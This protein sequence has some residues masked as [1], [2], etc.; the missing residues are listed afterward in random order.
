MRREVEAGILNAKL[1]S[2]SIRTFIIEIF[3]FAILFGFASKS[4]IV[5][6]VLVL[7]PLIAYGTSGIVPFCR[8]LIMIFGGMYSF[9][10]GIAVGIIFSAFSVTAGI[11]MG[12][13][14]FLPV[15]Y[16]NWCAINYFR[17]G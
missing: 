14:V 9:G 1:T 2:H 3:L 4:W 16:Y 10:W 12:V 13:I 15:A 5:F 6:G 7:L 8:I 17:H 11:V